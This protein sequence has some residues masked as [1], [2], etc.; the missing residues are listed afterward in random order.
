MKFLGFNTNRSSTSTLQ[1]VTTKAED[2]SKYIINVKT[3]LRA[4][5]NYNLCA[6]HFTYG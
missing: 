5:E 2:I 3:K 1:L 6:K 4:K